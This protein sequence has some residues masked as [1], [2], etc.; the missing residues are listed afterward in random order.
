ML[1]QSRKK[2]V[3]Q[4]KIPTVLGLIILIGALVAGLL[5]F[6]D[7]TGV[8]APRA[9]PETT[10]ATIRLTNVKEN[11]FTVT[12]YTN[13]A[14]A[15]FIKYG[16]EQG[17]LNSQSSDDRDQ[18][19]GTVGE[20]Q[21]HHITIRGLEPDTEYFYVLG[22]GSRAELDNEGLPFSIKTAGKPISSA[23]NALTIYGSVANQSGTPAEGG[24]VY[25]SAADTGE[26]SSLIK[27]SGSWAI[28]L[29]QARTQD[30]NDYAN[31]SVEDNISLLIQGL[32]LEDRLQLQTTVAEA[33]PVSE[34]IFGTEAI[35]QTEIETVGVDEEPETL[36]ESSEIGAVESS[37]SADV[38]VQETDP[39]ADEETEEESSS[40]SGQLQDLLAEAEPLPQESSASTELLIGELKETTGDAAVIVYTTQ[41][42]IIKGKVEPNVEVKIEVHSDSQYEE[43]VTADENGEFELDLAALQATLEPG[44][45]TVT[46][47]YVDPDTGEEV[48]KT[49]TFIVE[50][51]NAVRLASAEIDD[52]LADDDEEEL[53]AQADTET[54]IPYGSGDPYPLTS[55]TPSTLV[56]TSGVATTSTDGAREQLVGTDS[57]LTEAGSI[58]ATM[59]LILAGIFFVSIG[60]WSWWL[61]VELE[62][63]N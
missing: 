12:F 30:G 34:L 25:V 49:E 27:S 57:S 28:P 22:T 45:H 53:L 9:T 35:N 44:E 7:G 29:S 6:G 59:L 17:K 50:D 24:I 8:F 63:E 58:E 52:N 41:A 26:M 2:S 61:A 55:P 54:E 14:T 39:L 10:P 32:S 11:S 56:P 47:S 21:L 13:E 33:Q 62:Q 60:S 3:M 40:I 19:S 38:S 23:P 48:I 4:K 16:K 51:S 15:G 37:D 36:S 1:G 43:T 42:P 31:L 5:F 18:L 20:Y 46:Y